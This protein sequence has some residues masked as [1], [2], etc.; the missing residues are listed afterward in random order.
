MQLSGSVSVIIPAY[1]RQTY[2]A[3]AVR[4][5]LSQ[6]QSPLEVIVVDDG[7]TDGTRQ[8]LEQFFSEVRYEVQPHCGAGAARNRGAELASAEFL[9]FLDADDMW[10]PHKVARQL[11]AFRLRP[12]LDMVYGQVRQL[13]DGPEWLSGISE[14]APDL[15]QSI[16][17]YAAGALMVRRDAFF[18]VGPFSLDLKIGEFIDWYARARELGL[19]ETCL[20][21]LVLFRRIHASNQGIVERASRSDYAKVLKAS[22]DRRR[23]LGQNI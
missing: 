12:D 10:P 7:S 6:S 11:E 22:L 19:R 17:G 16:P 20:P 3:E 21:D 18:R 15:S 23:A 9:A 4:S 1:N 5:A 2:I 14:T 8:V 13:H